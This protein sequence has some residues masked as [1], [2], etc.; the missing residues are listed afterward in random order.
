[1]IETLLNFFKRSPEETT[2]EV[3]KG[4]CPNCW[5]KQEY[6]NQIRELY[7]DQQVDVNNHQA[8]HAFI[9]D[10]VV[11]RVEGI[12]LKRGN[13]GHECPTCRTRVPEDD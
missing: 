13:N 9:K 7:K 2:S 4:M 3:P 12:H 6:D 10:F 5:G 8:N 1:M 11:S